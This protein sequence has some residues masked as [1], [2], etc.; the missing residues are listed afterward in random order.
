MKGRI[1]LLCL[2]LLLAACQK[3]EELTSTA[4]PAASSAHPSATS[5]TRSE[6][7]PPS[8]GSSESPSGDL[9]VPPL[10]LSEPGRPPHQLGKI[11][12]ADWQAEALNGLMLELYRRA[13]YPAAATAGQWAILKGGNGR[14]DLACCLALSDRL[15]EA[16][17]YLQQAALLEGVDPIHA[18][19][20]PDLAILRSD[21]RWESVAAYLQAMNA[22]WS[23]S[24]TLK[25]SL[26]VPLQYQAGKPIPVVVGLHGLGG[27]QNFVDDNCQDLANKLG[28]AFLG[29]SGTVCLGPTAFR[30]SEDPIRDQAHIQEALDSVRDRITPAPG[31]LLLFGFSQGAELAFEIAACHPD[32]YRGALCF[33]PGLQQERSLDGLTTRAPIRQRFLITAGAAEQPDTLRH[34]RADAQWCRAHDIPVRLKIYPGVNSHSF[35]P[36]FS[37]QFG[38]WLQWVGSPKE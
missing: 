35:P 18:N 19:E 20:D 26:V 31:Q 33:S 7:Q 22:H 30:W 34:A 24:D 25:T 23:T 8:G 13:D 1:S 32:L 11:D 14:Y 27:N 36:D 6:E 17:Y 38:T 28:I 16:F 9:P 21:S 37:E 2:A 4:T 5:Q 12:L 10:P 29:V 15:E 3:P